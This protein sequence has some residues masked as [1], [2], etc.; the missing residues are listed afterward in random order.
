[1]PSTAQADYSSFLRTKR[2]YLKVNPTN[3]VTP[4]VKIETKL[5]ALDFRSLPVVI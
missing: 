3:G 2:G 5:S 1:M 4:I